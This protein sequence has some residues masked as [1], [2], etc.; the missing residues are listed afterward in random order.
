[1]E[2]NIKKKSTLPIIEVDMLKSGRLDYRYNNTDLSTATIYFYMKDIENGVYKIAKANAVFSSENNT[3]Y[4]QF[5]KKNTGTPG[6]YEGEFKIETDQGI[7]DLPL[8]DK[9]FINVLESF[10]NTDFCCSTG[11]NINPTP[12]PPTPAAPGIYYGKV[13]KETIN[14]G[15]ITSLTFLTTS[16]GNGFYVEVPAG[17]G[18]SYILVPTTISQPTGFRDSTG[19]CFG[20]NVPTNNIGTINL[21]DTNGFLVTYN[22][23]RS[24]FSFNG[25]VN[26]WLCS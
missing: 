2:F 23:Y 25:L 8:R 13:N 17:L 22:I 11:Q 3:I 1:M 12:I 24:Y 10:S 18:Y 5:S 20:F 15:D 19:G 21:A 4:Y 7:I 9:I 16:S 14:S 26:T 6:R